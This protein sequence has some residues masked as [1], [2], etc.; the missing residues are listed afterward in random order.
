MLSDE[1]GLLNDDVAALAS[2]IATTKSTLFCLDAKGVALT[3]IWT[4]FEVRSQS[5]PDCGGG[6]AELRGENVVYLDCC[7]L[8]I[9]AKCYTPFI[10]P[11]L[12]D[13]RSER[14][15]IP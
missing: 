4:L 11:G 6:S 5:T 8:G 13:S 10:I 1:M 15:R 2:V 12:E 14:C 9:V 3:R 7:L